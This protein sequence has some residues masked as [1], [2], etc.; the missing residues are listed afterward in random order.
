MPKISVA[1]VQASN[2]G[3]A[4]WSEYNLSLMSIIDTLDNHSNLDAYVCGRGQIAL[5]DCLTL[6]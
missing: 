3:P 4:L 1:G 5:S 2:T 6:P